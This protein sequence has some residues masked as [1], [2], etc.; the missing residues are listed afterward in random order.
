MGKK[1]KKKELMQ[2]KRTETA[3]S[4]SK[5]IRLAYFQWQRQMEENSCLL[6]LGSKLGMKN[7]CLHKNK[8]V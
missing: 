5:D 4:E 1:K 3:F 2:K 7:N 8:Y 6:S